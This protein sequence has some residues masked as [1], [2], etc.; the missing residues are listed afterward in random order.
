MKTKDQ[1]QTIE[2]KWPLGKTSGEQ[3]YHPGEIEI[4]WQEKWEKEKLYRAVDFDKRPK[5]Y[6]LVEFPYPSGERL[7]VGHGRSF[8]A[9]D[10]LARK[11]RMMGFNVLYPFGWDAFGLPA[12]NYAIKTGINP[13]VTTA[14]NIANSKKQAKTWALS[15]DWEREVNTTDP[16]YYKWTQWIFLKLLEK[17]LAYRADVPVNWC[18]SCKTN[19][20][21]EE[22]LADGTHERCGC[23]TER[24]MQKQW[25]LKI[26][27]Y[28]QRLLD[29]LKIVN[30]LPRIRIQQ[31][32]WIGRS[33]G[34]KIKFPIS[35]LAIEVF[36]TRPDTLFGA[37]ALVLAPE[38]PLLK[39]PEI[40]KKMP[41]EVAVYL[42][43]SQKKSELERT[44]LSKEKTGVFT[45][46]YALNP[47]N[48][49]KLPV[50]VGDY[51][52]GWYGEGAVMVVPAHDRRDYQF[53]KKYHLEI[54]EVVSGGEIQKEAYEGEGKLLNS[55]EFSGLSS[56]AARKKVTDWLAK[57]QLG[58]KT[59]QYKLRDWVF[60]RQHYWG[61]PIPVIYCQKCG[62]VPVPEKDLPV[63]LPYMEKYQPTE[64]GESPLANIKEWV[65]VAC[66]KCGGSARRETDTMPNWAG[67]N[68]YFLRYC[69]AKNQQKFA[70][71]QKLNYWMPVDLYN[72]GMEHTTLHLLYSRFIYKFLADLGVVPG[73][74]PYARRHSHGVV[75]GPDNQ[76][77]SKSKGNVINPDEIVKAY[78]VDAYR[79]YESF[80]G[81]FEQM[82]AW[83][84]EGVEGCYRFLKRVW[85][86]TMDKTSREKTNPELLKALHK[87]IK[88]VGEDLENLKFNTAVAAMMEFINVW[89][90]D[91]RGLNKSDLEKFLLILAPFAPYLTEELWCENLGN[92]FSIHKQRW[93]SFEADKLEE[94][95]V[96]ILIE[97]NGRLKDK[98]MIEFDLRNDQKEVEKRALSQEKIK[99]DLLGKKVKKTIFIPGKLINFVA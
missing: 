17:G 4:K 74:E 62:A 1:P 94:K 18:P 98:M 15:F 34:A 39:M 7:H 68:W 8:T 52:I 97:I 16:D 70:D 80:M 65:E 26:T 95:I 75:L 93:P 11:Y 73:Q 51:V 58:E 13:A 71:R 81:P 27:A 14:Q 5:K 31:E 12:E 44:D 20:A 22:V 40:K 83:S 57:R 45:G 36:T 46:L 61:E 9:I 72:G 89:Q 79:L 19:L 91:L 85:Q 23:Q 76:K 67:S 33:E 92:Q 30:Y 21:Q 37:V 90:V 82:I 78:G 66:P 10:A 50:W 77:M 28:A 35:N 60:S 99:K 25:L 64:T 6:L 29:D 42:E 38:H 41:K 24:R 43:R 56:L 87:T 88:K 3:S 96:T 54:K 53:A 63:E 2:K 86:L 69:D 49:E 32:N 55:G 59:V 84:D 48:K 47:L